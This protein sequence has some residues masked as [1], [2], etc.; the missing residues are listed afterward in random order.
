[1][2]SS[3]LVARP[4]VPVAGVLAVFSTP[5]LG[6]EVDETALDAVATGPWVVRLPEVHGHDDDHG[7]EPHH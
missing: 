6:V 7:D 3:D 1:M 5:G 4:I 2:C